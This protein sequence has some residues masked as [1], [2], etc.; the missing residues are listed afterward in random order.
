MRKIKKIK[1]LKV[2]LKTIFL[3]S[4]AG[5]NKKYKI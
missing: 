3:F 4:G 5:E 1:F 2:T